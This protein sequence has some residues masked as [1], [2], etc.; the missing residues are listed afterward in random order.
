MTDRSSYDRPVKPRHRHFRPKHWT[1]LA[2]AFAAEFT[3][4][5]V[6]IL[7]GKLWITGV[8]DKLFW[9]FHPGEKQD[10]TLPGEGVALLC[11][12]AVAAGV[13]VYLAL[14]AIRRYVNISRS[15]ALAAVLPCAASLC[16]LS[17]ALPIFGD[18]SIGFA[19]PID[20]VPVMAAAGTT[21]AAVTFPARE[22]HDGA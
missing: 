8:I 20:P 5:V 19:G 17:A 1:G 16:L 13:A 14:L 11:T 15:A 21:L 2:G 7:S 10:L 18:N 6:A 4:G 12:L 3:G 22:Q 9:S